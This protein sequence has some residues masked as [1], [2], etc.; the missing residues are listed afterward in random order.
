M[1]ESPTR[2]VSAPRALILGIGAGVVLLIVFIL[3]LLLWDR[4]VPDTRA[5]IQHDAEDEAAQITAARSAII[6]HEPDA[7]SITFGKVAV[8]W[9]G[10]SPAV[11]G[12]VDIDEPQDS[13]DGE[14]RFVF[15]DGELTLESLDGSDA[16]QEKWKDVCD[17]V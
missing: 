14:E 12:K 9:I 6:A 17:D 10:E 1:A 15:I 8:D 16:V 13:L 3:A 5:Q 4:I 7:D 11:C 2:S